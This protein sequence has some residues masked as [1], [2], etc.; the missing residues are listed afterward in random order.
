MGDAGKA[1]LDD[2]PGFDLPA[3]GPPKSEEELRDSIGLR[4]R[5]PELGAGVMG[6]G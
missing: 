3:A 5:Q 2:E 4:S 1:P 6:S